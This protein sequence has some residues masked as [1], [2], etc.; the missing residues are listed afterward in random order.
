MINFFCEIIV[1]LLFL[2]N[3]KKIPFGSS[4]VLIILGIPLIFLILAE[5]IQ[6]VSKIYMFILIVLIALNVLLATD[7]SYELIAVFNF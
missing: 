5:L 4:F 7:K 3:S 2:T 1:P 6:K